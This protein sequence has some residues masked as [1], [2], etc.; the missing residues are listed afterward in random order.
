MCARG[1]LAFGPA[2][3]GQSTRG[4]AGVTRSM[5]SHARLLQLIHGI[6]TCPRSRQARPSGSH[7]SRKQAVRP[8]PRSYLFN[9]DTPTWNHAD[10]DF[11][12]AD[13]TPA[14]S[15]WIGA[16][17]G[18]QRILAGN[19][20]IGGVWTTNHSDAALEALGLERNYPNWVASSPVEAWR[21]NTMSAIQSFGTT[22]TAD[23]PRAP[24]RRSTS[25]MLR[26]SGLTRY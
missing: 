11:S 23:K 15:L 14:G 21:L 16:F 25:G 22:G 24:A 1:V 19:I 10:M 2:C 12:V 13:V 8:P 18:H 17:W 3:W 20:L 6:S 4:L 9:Y 7:S 26:P 5:F